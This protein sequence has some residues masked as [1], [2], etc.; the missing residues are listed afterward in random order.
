MANR[1]RGSYSPSWKGGLVKYARGYL[2][3]YAPDHPRVDSSG[4]VADHILV[5]EKALGCYLP[6]KVEVHHVN[7]NKSDNR[8]CNLV[9]CEDSAYHKLLHIRMRVLKAG[10][11][12]NTHKLCNRCHQ[13]LTFDKFTTN[14]SAGDG[15]SQYC[16][17]CFSAYKKV[18]RRNRRMEVK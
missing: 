14:K 6:L 9:I 7:E 17:L 4:R 5:A 10:G 3:R 15:L 2:R 12:P 11:D 1:K 18:W 13:P 16:R 8:N